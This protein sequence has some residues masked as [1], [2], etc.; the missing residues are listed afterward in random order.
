MSNV[1]LPMRP[2]QQK[3]R[4]RRKPPAPRTQRSGSFPFIVMGVVALCF[5]S[6]VAGFMAPRYLSD[7][8][9][10]DYT[11]EGTGSVTITVDPGATLYDIGLQLTANGVTASSA[12]FTQAAAKDENAVNL[13]PG[14]Y[15]L[16]QQM[17]GTAALA[18]MQDPAARVVSSFTIPEGSRMS[19]VIKIAS[20]ATGIPAAEFLQVV[21]NP[22]DLS[23]PAYANGNPEG[24]LYPAKYEFQPDSTALEL[25]QAMVAKFNEVARNLNLEAE[26]AKQGRNP[27]DVVITASLVEAEG[28]PDDFGKVSRVV[29]N[30]LAAG[31][32]LQFDSTSNYASD[33]SNIQLT[34]EQKNEDTPY[35]TYLYNGLTP[36]PIGQPGEAALK[37]AL[38]PEEG[39]WLFFVA[40]NPDT[41]VTKFTKD[42]E[43]FLGWVDELNAY[44]ATRSPQPNETPAQ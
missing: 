15:Q 11:G 36:T 44:L 27:Y 28:H 41:K 38:F 4:A 6:L 37:A 35:N 3:P 18:L 5:M 21:Q 20:E 34:D 23:L 30:R 2:T 39:D 14:T 7:P 13:Q 8:A 40:V 29:S 31:M 33:S 17:S 19:K 43:E 32:P 12:A 25:M 24:F 42:Y 10:P 16:R 1:G 22:Q 26:A 9:V